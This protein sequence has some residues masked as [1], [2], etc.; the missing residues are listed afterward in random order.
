MNLQ[1]RQ[2]LI[3]SLIT[4]LPEIS[5][6]LVSLVTY[7]NGAI[8]KDEAR[9]EETVGNVLRDLEHLVAN[10]APLFKY[11]QENTLETGLELEEITLYKNFLSNLTQGIRFMLAWMKDKNEPEGKLKESVNMLFAAG[12]Q[13]L[14]LVNLITKD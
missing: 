1:N 6:P 13:I 5:T 4:Y 14:E 2:D 12:Q 9:N 3:N 8:E 11:V 7:L 10:L